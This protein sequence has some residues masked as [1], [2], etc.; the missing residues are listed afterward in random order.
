MIMSQKEIPEI[1]PPNELKLLAYGES[2]C[3]VDQM[4]NVI[5]VSVNDNSISNDEKENKIK[6]F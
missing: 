2:N 4:K 5:V 1:L 3:I 6:M